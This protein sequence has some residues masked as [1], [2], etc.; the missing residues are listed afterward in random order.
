MKASDVRAIYNLSVDKRSPILRSL[1][2][3]LCR[4]QVWVTCLSSGILLSRPLTSFCSSFSFWTH[5]WIPRRTMRGNGPC[6]VLPV[7][8]ASLQKWTTLEWVGACPGAWAFIPTLTPNF[9]YYL[10]SITHPFPLF[11]QLHPLFV[12]CAS[13]ILSFLP[14]S[15]SL[16][17]NSIPFRLV[18]LDSIHLIKQL[19]N[20]HF[21]SGTM[22]GVTV[23]IWPRQFPVFMDLYSPLGREACIEQ[24]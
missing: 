19:L 7:F 2:L 4:S 11:P 14:W 8:L 1:V 15:F 9:T 20:T 24:T 5:G 12:S 10:A 13:H 22:V 18:Q 17:T 23:D 16:L 21:V 3:I 6:G